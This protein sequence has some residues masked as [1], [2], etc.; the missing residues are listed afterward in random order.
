MT[1]ADTFSGGVAVGAMS[2]VS[3]KNNNLNVITSKKTIVF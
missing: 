2:N 1:S 3:Q